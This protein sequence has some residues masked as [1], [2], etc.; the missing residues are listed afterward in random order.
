MSRYFY[1]CFLLT[2]FINGRISSQNNIDAYKLEE[3][4][5]FI[6]F[7]N[8][9]SGIVFTD[10]YCSAI[11]LLSGG[12]V[13]KIVESPGCG[14]YF[15]ISP[16]K[17]K[18]GF[19]YID[20]NGYQTPAYFD[21]ISNRVI[22]LHTPVKL[23]GQV[24]F[25]ANDQMVF[26]IADELYVINHNSTAIFPLGTYSNITAV[27]PDGHYVIFTGAEEQ[28]LLLDL[29]TK[30]ETE[31][32]ENG[33]HFLYPCWS[34]DSKKVVM[35][36]YDGLLYVFDKDNSIFYTLG[37]GNAPVW[38]ENSDFLYYHQLEIQKNELIN[39]DI[40][41]SRFDRTEM[42]KL[43]NTMDAAELYPEIDQ[44]SLICM[45]LFS[46]KIFQFNLSIK[47]NASG[48]PKLL[49]AVPDTL[50]I[51]FFETNQ[52]YQNKLRA[53]KRIEN[54][55][56]INQK[57]DCPDWH[58]GSGSCAPA[59]A[60]MVLAYYNKLPKW[61]IT[62]SNPFPHK[63]FYGAYVA[64]MY[65]Y[66]GFIFNL[67]ATAYGSA[68]WGAYGYMWNGASSPNSTMRQFLTIH[69]INSLQRWTNGCI[70]VN[71][72][73]EIDNG[74]THPIC[75]WLTMAGHVTL[76]AGYIEGKMTLIF[77]D[78]YGNKN[79]GYPNFIGSYVYYD[80]PGFN[81]GY[82]N[83]DGDGTHGM[84]AWTVTARGNQPVYSDTIID[85][86]YFGHGFE[87]VNQPPAHMK[88]YHDFKA[89]YKDHSWWTNTTNHLPDVCSVSW[90]PTL[91]IPGRYMIS[92]FIPAGISEAISARYRVHSQDGDTIIIINQSLYKNSWVVLG[93]YN[94]NSGQSGFVTLGDYTGISNQKLSMDAMKWE[95]ANESPIID[96]QAF[97]IIPNPTRSEFTL[98]IIVPENRK[99][100]VDL[101]DLSGRFI[102]RLVDEYFYPGKDKRTIIISNLHY[103]DNSFYPVKGIYI[104]RYADSSGYTTNR[105]LVIL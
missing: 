6:N 81:N 31:I 45:D 64:D 14:R 27:S 70:F 37:N 3:K 10:N 42:T 17:D 35:K 19:K 56:Y 104:L 102:S 48:N 92:V 53:E 62:A 69:D 26:T 1:F 57:F 55:P 49:Y 29:N 34:P 43:T 86:I 13:K 71:T 23:C 54:V 9:P 75:S 38:S 98:K 61:E 66:N 33:D 90:H 47:I 41:R 85:D 80:W 67:A 2:L 50:K 68:A 52:F 15:S 20:H 91:K 59:T 16:A 79:T 93:I 12:E 87:M 8:T 21:L 94:F 89:G 7:K 51:N 83:L 28:L 63:S 88:Y 58:N 40:F 103:L 60:A 97:D 36:G 76:A 74:F 46:R 11:Y 82:Q 99:V 100:N 4:G 95:K 72:V 84:V 105:K 18:I 65:N 24:S 101:Y 5:Y 78:P 77:N 30:K 39:S 25:S 44:N 96:I 73:N 22:K 32:S